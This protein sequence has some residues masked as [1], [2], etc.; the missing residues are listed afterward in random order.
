MRRR[1]GDLET[2]YATMS[3]VSDDALREAEEA[4]MQVSLLRRAVEEKDAHIARAENSL[5]QLSVERSRAV[6]QHEELE[7]K[8]QERLQREISQKEQEL[9]DEIE[10]LKK[11]VEVKDKKLQEAMAERGKAEKRLIHQGGGIDL[12]VG[13]QRHR[14][15]MLDAH[16]AIA[17]AFGD[18]AEEHPCTRLFD[19][20]MLRVTAAL[21]KHPVFRRLFFAASGLM[22]VFALRHALIPDSS[23]GPSIHF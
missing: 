14:E 10:F 15:A 8:F 17:K 7:A 1:V 19:D 12:P 23:T 2:Q 16:T 22:W 20:P 5:D 13:V 11:S 3:A 18:T 21:F 9:L 6:H 4:K